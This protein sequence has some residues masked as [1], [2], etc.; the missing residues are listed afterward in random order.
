LK[1]LFLEKSFSFYQFLF[2]NFLVK[3]TPSTSLSLPC[4]AHLSDQSTG[5]TRPVTR[6]VP[7]GRLLPPSL[8]RSSPLSRLPWRLR[9]RAAAALDSDEPRRSPP[10]RCRS[11][12]RSGDGGSACPRDLL[13]CVL[14]VC[15]HFRPRSS[16]LRPWRPRARSRVAR[17]RPRWCLGLVSWLLR[18]RVI[19]VFLWLDAAVVARALPRHATVVSPGRCVSASML[20]LFLCTL[21]CLAGA[22]SPPGACPHACCSTLLKLAPCWLSPP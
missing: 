11:I 7:T 14:V 10:P 4:L 2:F 9:H 1:S 5:R 17:P 6:S 16:G 3:N 8:T 18:R 20:L 19:G 12:D 15:I 13:N 22:C 21:L